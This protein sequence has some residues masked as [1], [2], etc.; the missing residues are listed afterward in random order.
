MRTPTNRASRRLFYAI[1]PSP[2]VTSAI[3]AVATRLQKGAN[4]TSARIIW[5][6]PANYHVTLFFLGEVAADTAKRLADSLSDAATGV[7]TFDLD[8]RK[9]DFFPT[10]GGRPP[11]VLWAGIHNPSEIIA[12]LRNNCASAIAKARLPVPD[13]DF[14]P[15]ITL[16]RFKSTAGLA[17]FRD[18]VGE[19]RNTRFGKCPV[20]R[21]VLMESITGGGPARYQPFATATL[22]GNS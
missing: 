5:V 4:F 9:L 20:D 14:S 17:P 18:M 10:D 16:A 11:R 22:G 21:L 8:V 12:Q 3:A 2:E 1:V 7:P 15:H 13:Q 19:Y 6:P